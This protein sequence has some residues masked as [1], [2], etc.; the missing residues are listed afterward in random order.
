MRAMNAVY[1]DCSLQQYFRLSNL[2]A[3]MEKQLEEERNE[4]IAKSNS[5]IRTIE[6]INHQVDKAKAE[7]EIHEQRVKSLV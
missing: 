7:V 6:S 3:W 1:V 4:A 2:L 5:S